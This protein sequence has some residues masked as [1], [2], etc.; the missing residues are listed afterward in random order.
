MRRIR[1]ALSAAVL[2]AFTGTAAATVGPGLRV[3]TMN[4]SGPVVVGTPLSFDVELMARAPMTVKNLQMPPRD[5]S[6][7]SHDFPPDSIFM[8]AGSTRLV[9]ITATPDRTEAVL[10]LKLVANGRIVSKH[11]DFTRRNYDIT[12]R[13]NGITAMPE[14]DSLPPVPLAPE[15]PVFEP[16]PLRPRAEG[17]KPVRDARAAGKAA[18]SHDVAIT[19]RFV[20]TRNDNQIVGAD[21]VTVRVYDE[22]WDWDEYLGAVLTNS[23]GYFSITVSCS[24]GE[25]DLYC[26]LETDNSGITVEDGTFW[27]TNYSWTTHV[28]EDFGGSYLNYGSFSIQN[29]SLRPALHLFTNLNRT[30]RFWK[31]RMGS[32]PPKVEAQ[33]PDHDWPNY[34]GELHIPNWVNGQPYHWKSDTHVHEYGHHL[35]QSFGAT[36][37]PEYDNGV[38]NNANGDPGH[39]AW[40]QETDH[41]AMGEGWPNWLSDVVTRDYASSYGLASNYLRPQESLTSNCKDSDG[42]P[43]NCDPYKTEGFLGALCTDLEDPSSDVDPNGGGGQ[44]QDQLSLGPTFVLRLMGDDN[45]LTPAQLIAAAKARLQP[46]QYDE[47]WS[48]LRNAGYPNTD[49]VK[50]SLPANFHS[51]DHAVGYSSP[52]NTIGLEWDAAT[53]DFSGVAGYSIQVTTTL[54]QPNTSIE[55][56]GTAWNTAPLPLGTYYATIRTIDRA[57]NASNG[58]ALAGPYEIR[59]P[60]P[61]DFAGLASAGWFD[62]VVPR[63][64][65]TATTATVSLPTSLPGNLHQTYW[66]VSAANISEQTN[67]ALDRVRLLLDG[68]PVDSTTLGFYGPGQYIRAINRGPITVRGGRHTLEAW[69]DAAEENA[70]P[71]ETNN[72]YGRQYVWAPLPIYW[73]STYT[74]PAPPL[75][76]GGWNSFTFPIGVPKWFNCDGFTYSHLGTRLGTTYWTGASAYSVDD[77]ADVDLMLHPHSTGAEDSFTTGLA[78]SARGAGQLDAVFTSR[79]SISTNRW[80]VGV[81]NHDANDAD[82][83]VRQA[84][85]TTASVGETLVVSFP[86]GVMLAVV[87]LHATAANSGKIAVEVQ[88]PLLA[89]QVFTLWFGPSFTYGSMNDFDGKV[90]TGLTG[91][92]QLTLTSSGDSYHGLAFYRNPA[93]GRDSMAF[94]VRIYEK[95]SDPTPTQPKGWY[96]ANPPRC[97]TNATLGSVPQPATLTGDTQST[98][99]NVAVANQSEIFLSSLYAQLS[100]DGTVLGGPVLFS[101]APDDTGKAINTLPKVI[102]GGRHMLTMTLDPFGAVQ[103]MDEDNNRFADQWVWTPATQPLEAPVWRKGTNGGK[104]AGWSLVDPAL[105]LEYNADGIR[106]PVFA[107]AQGIR[108]AGVAVMPRAGSD[109]DLRL[110]KLANGSRSGF[111]EPLED[112]GWGPGGTDFVLMHFP[113]APYQA[114]DAGIVRSS[115]DTSSYVTQ[116]VTSIP[117]ASAVGTL[118]PF[119]M[120][121]GDLLDL[122]EFVLPVGHYVVTLVNQAGTNVDWG[123]A[124]YGG[125]RPYQNRL[126]GLDMDARWTNGPGQG[127]QIEFNVATA[128]EHCIAVWK[129]SGADAFAGGTYHLQIDV[130]TTGVAGSSAEERSRLVSARPNP[131]RPNSELRFALARAGHARVEV[132][133]LRG[134]RVRVLADR[135]MAP[136]DHRVAWDGR[137]DRGH[138]MQAGV[139]LVR[140]TAPDRADALRI[141]KVE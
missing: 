72:R 26:E 16:A 66:N 80:D 21:G 23:Q 42:N 103:E 38:C 101:I 108:W 62:P 138:A 82:F 92:S 141:V 30:A 47:F 126:A 86:A 59:E 118:G 135:E 122:H 13:P 107:A 114:F 109:V 15:A 20:Y 96:S 7:I 104:T 100:L 45:A 5:Y 89:S 17:R 110:H 116:V 43:C 12:H 128:G 130:N 50:P 36:A 61:A 39:C 64:D 94:T 1:W 73:D 120:P 52:D 74:R 32:T 65:N 34:D 24:E 136:G 53:D 3:R 124:V 105:E 99:F 78:T 139:Y 90:A 33:W 134:A 54:G 113:I 14:L 56:T 4:L 22:D 67:T 2:A 6:G 71:N 55:T 60:Y 19:G 133:D 123:L 111:A 112:S 70:E 9:H 102:P 18:G 119:T 75:K 40:C 10:D 48:T 29:S 115:N 44:F 25:P 121:A 11:L 46:G 68:T 35:M 28:K 137:D 51:T 49:T 125:D 87:E 127:E 69:Q 76:D 140:L 63:G 106:T 8:P 88:K 95:N 31:S 79:R 129:H 83:V 132:F 84:T 93:S 131:F 85:S 77:A 97:D 57:G 41:D 37:S 58:Y 98:W 27:E 81:V 117:H 91:K